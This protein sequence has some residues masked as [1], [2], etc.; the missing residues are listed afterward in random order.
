[1]KNKSCHQYLIKNISGA[2][3]QAGRADLNRC[4]GAFFGAK[5]RWSELQSLVLRKKLGDLRVELLFFGEV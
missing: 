4:G 1:M 3:L 2:R 5:S